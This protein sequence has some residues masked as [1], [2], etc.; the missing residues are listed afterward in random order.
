MRDLV[1][2]VL[3]EAGGRGKQRPVS[4]RD[5]DHDT[6]DTKSPIRDIPTI[7]GGAKPTNVKMLVTVL[8]LAFVLTVLMLVFVVLGA[9]P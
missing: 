1:R 7:P 5:W 4:R 3:F 2:A 9:L 8:L 6:S